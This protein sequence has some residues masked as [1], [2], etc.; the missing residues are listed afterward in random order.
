MTSPVPP[1]QKETAPGIVEGR[2]R[3]AMD[4]LAK[5]REGV[6]AKNSELKKLRVTSAAEF[7]H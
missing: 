2:K 3:K 6:L 1:E 4:E 7:S 5:G